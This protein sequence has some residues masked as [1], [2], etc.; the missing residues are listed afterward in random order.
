MGG[1]ALN[2]NCPRLDSKTYKNLETK[3]VSILK[4][5]LPCIEIPRYFKSKK[6]FG[7]VDLLIYIDRLTFNE[8]QRGRYF[9]TH[10]EIL[11]SKVEWM[12]VGGVFFEFWGFLVDVKFVYSVE[13][14]DHWNVLLA[15]GGLGMMLGLVLA[16]LDLKWN[17]NGLWLKVGEGLVGTA[18]QFLGQD[19]FFL[20]GDLDLIFGFLGLDRKTF[21]ETE[22]KD[23]RELFDYLICCRLLDLD[24]V[25]GF[26][27]SRKEVDLRLKGFWNFV[28]RKKPYGLDKYSSKKFVQEV[29]EF[30]KMRDEFEK[31]V[32]PAKRKAVCIEKFNSVQ[33]QKITHLYGHELK[34]FM[35]FF[36][37]SFG[38]GEEA[39]EEFVFDYPEIDALIYEVF[40]SSKFCFS[41]EM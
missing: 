22:F 8:L 5:D 27:R 19:W 11:S 2:L 33:V 15:Y 17:K 12:G 14:L 31:L 37:K 36:K 29:L 40:A 25:C 10:P 3:L 7:D 1:R 24:R 35:S 38:G 9:Q 16:S 21:E 23:E 13:E 41:K 4:Q 28:T 34:E 39:F 20:S 32:L 18:I 26:I 30:F 6:T